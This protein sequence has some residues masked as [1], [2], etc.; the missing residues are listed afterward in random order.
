MEATYEILAESQ[1]SRELFRDFKRYQEVKRCWRKEEDGWKLKEI[2]FIE[3]WGEPEYEF[4]VKCLKNTVK[5][6][7]F[8]F[9]CFVEGKLA[10]FTSVENKPFGSGKQYVQLSSIHISQESRGRGYGSKL[11]RC[12]VSAGRMMGAEKLYISAHSA[13]ETQA[14]YHAMGC[15]EAEEYNLEL[16][17]AEPCDCQLEYV[18]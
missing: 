10:G 9:G 5:T 15:V 17:A 12:A 16:F 3:E 13:E 18:L 14:F 4:L 7:G 6:G 11:F 2:P 8:V 1:I